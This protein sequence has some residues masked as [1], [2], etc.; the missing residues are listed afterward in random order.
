MAKTDDFDL[1]RHWRLPYGQGLRPSQYLFV[2]EDLFHYDYYGQFEKLDE[3]IA[4]LEN[5]FGYKIETNAEKHSDVKNKITKY[6]DFDEQVKFH[7]TYPLELRK[8]A[9]F[10][11]SKHFYTAELE[12]LVR[13]RYAADLKLYE[14][15]FN[16]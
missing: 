6:Q 15:N 16:L 3:A 10:P 8:L 11:H 9:G 2:G 1:N 12:A 4:F 7:N 5:K 13:K 14:Q